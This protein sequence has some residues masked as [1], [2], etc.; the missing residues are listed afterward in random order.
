MADCR[1]QKPRHGEIG[2]MMRK[3]AGEVMTPLRA[4]RHLPTA[5][6]MD[7]PVSVSR[8]QRMISSWRKTSSIVGEWVVA[9]ICVR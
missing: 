2:L 3:A 7:V 5:G 4:L 9:M 1:F 6:M 8:S